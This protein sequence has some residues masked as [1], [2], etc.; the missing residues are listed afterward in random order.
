MIYLAIGLQLTGIWYL[1]TRNDFKSIMF[2][3]LIFIVSNVLI[4]SL[5]GLEAKAIEEFTIFMCGLSF[6][7]NIVCVMYFWKTLKFDS[8]L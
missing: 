5:F 4:L 8:E 6:I 7:Y 3:Q 1:I 2:G